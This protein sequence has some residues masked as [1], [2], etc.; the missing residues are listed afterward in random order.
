M[1]NYMD[2]IDRLRERY[3]NTRVDMDVYNAKYL[4]EGFK[5]TEGQP[6]I[7]QKATGYLH[8]CQKKNI[9]ILDDELLVG[10]AGF[11]PRAGILCA[12]SSCSILDRELDTISTRKFDPFYLSEE[13]KKVFKEEVSDYWKNRCV[14]D[15]WQAMAPDDMKLLRDNGMIYIDRKAVR[16]YGETTPAWDLILS[17]GIGG[18]R[19][20]AVAALAKLDDAKVGD[21]E[22]IQFLKAE[23]I[24]CDG[25]ITLANRHADL[26][27]LMASDCKDSIRKAELEKI[28]AVCRRVPEHPATSYHEALQSILFY[29]YAIYMEQNASSYNLGRIDQYLYPY[30]RADIDNG[31][32][33]KDEA[34]ELLD[35]LWIK[36]AELSLFQDEVTAQFA[37]G[38]CVTIQVTAGGIDQYGNDAVNELSYMVIQATMDVKL[39]EPNM[40]VRYSIAKNPDSFLQKACEANRM[41]LTMPAVYHDDAGI[42]MMLNKGVPLSEAWDWNPC[43]CVETNLSGRMKQYTDMADMNMGGII[44][45]AL[46]DGVSRKTGERV[47]ISTGDAKNFKTFDDFFEAVKAHIRYFVDV[48]VSGNQLLDYLSMNYRPVPVL[49]LGFPDCLE[50]ATDYSMGGAKYNCG[51]GVITVGQAD[52]INSLAAVR[53]LVFDEKKVSMDELCQA[54]AA[55][56]EGYEEIQELC[57]EAP[58]YGNDDERADW[59]VGEVFTYVVDEFEKY[60]TKFGKMTTGM[61]PVSGNTPIGAW[62]GAL[63]SGRKAWTPLTD[64]IGATGGTDKNGPSAL[65]KSVSHIPHA[66][67]TQGTQLNMKLEPSILEGQRGISHMMNLLKTLCTLDVYH[68]QF[69]V[70]DREVL[71]DAQ[72]HPENHRGLLIRV[73]GYTA[74]YIELGKEVQDEIIGRTAIG[75]WVS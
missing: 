65:L 35:C 43:G 30:F 73:A 50:S 25:I 67:Y 26:A 45:M 3:L 9:Y 17:E 66:R 60:D 44:E 14:L 74:F 7:I 24:V 64:G 56:F 29:E 27:E 15:R 42:R 13:G 47:S 59:I 53:N 51:G 21:L 19:K 18:I 71:I 75:G 57:L 48:V 38:Y 39:K 12:D 20:K 34:Q 49:S 33:T 8:Q 22:K 37:A 1:N 32:M 61:L 52:I 31:V 16:G 69:N 62:V 28:A 23:I 10:G 2:R 4:T 63:P 55:N 41:G 58:K 68:V 11:K 5:E 72:K 36:I 46:N 54:L 6:W 70:V 40:S